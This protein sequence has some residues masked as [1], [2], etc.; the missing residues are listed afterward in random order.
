MT[1]QYHAYQCKKK[2]PG[3][4][5][6]RKGCVSRSEAVR[7]VHAEKSGCRMVIRLTPQ[8][9]FAGDDERGGAVDCPSEK[10]AYRFSTVWSAQMK[11]DDI[12]G[13]AVWRDARIEVAR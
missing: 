8:T 7:K 1:M 13:L 12:G 10:T 3:S 9:F 11:L 2:K 6:D 4:I 5:R